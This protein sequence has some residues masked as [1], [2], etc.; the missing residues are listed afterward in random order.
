MFGLK[1]KS[2]SCFQI[3]SFC[4]TFF[5]IKHENINRQGTQVS[6]I[7]NSRMT[8]AFFVSYKN[9]DKNTAGS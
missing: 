2:C 7:N 3:E 4:Y 5:V 6:D 1:L 9:G 8:D